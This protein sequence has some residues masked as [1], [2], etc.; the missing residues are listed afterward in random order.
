MVL[1]KAGNFDFGLDSKKVVEALKSLASKI[2]SG[3]FIVKATKETVNHES[4]EF[5]RK[6]FCV[7]FCQQ[8]AKELGEE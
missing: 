3:E 6:T 7:T 1:V 5:V 8:L 4:D 2:E